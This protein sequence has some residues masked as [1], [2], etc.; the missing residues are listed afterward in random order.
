MSGQSDQ[1]QD[2]VINVRTDGIIEEERA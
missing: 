1:C 2:R